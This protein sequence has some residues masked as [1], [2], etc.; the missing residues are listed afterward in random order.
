[1]DADARLS[2]LEDELRAQKQEALGELLEIHR[3]RLERLIHFRMAPAL[4]SR[5]EGGDVLQETYVAAADRIHRFAEDE[6]ESSFLWLRLLALQTLTD[7][8]RKHLGAQCRDARRDVALQRRSGGGGGATSIS[9]AAILADSITSPS[10]VAM[11]NEQKAE[12]EAA[13]ETLGEN[14]QEILALRHFEELS[15]QETARVLGIEEKAAS[16]RYIRALKRLKDSLSAD[17]LTGL[18][19]P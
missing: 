10:G 14:D 13:I 16:I 1:M 3:E 9:L 4:R 18:T 6:F 7:L 15:N 17:L 12:V 19:Q 5:V 11:R 8:H 2:Q